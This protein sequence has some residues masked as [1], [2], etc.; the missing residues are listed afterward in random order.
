MIVNAMR[1]IS[2]FIEEIRIYPVEQVR[3]Y[4]RMY[5]FP[6]PEGTEIVPS[7]VTATT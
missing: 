2:L 5:V 3:G 1:I 6:V 7:A 4:V